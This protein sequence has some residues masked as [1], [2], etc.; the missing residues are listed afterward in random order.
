MSTESAV[1]GTGSTNTT[2]GTVAQA[3]TTF[4]ADLLLLDPKNAEVIVVPKE[5]AKAFV[6]EANQ[7]AALCNTLA[8]SRE[9]VLE[10]EEKLAQANAQ[11]FPSLGEIQPLQNKLKQ[12][13]TA[14]EA[15]YEAVKKELGDKGYLATS[16][17]GKE[18]LELVP[19][20]QRKSGGKPQ[21]WARTWTYVRPEKHRSHWRSVPL[22]KHDKGQMP[23][24]IRDGKIDHQEL[25]KQFGKL[26]PKLK[27]EWSFDPA[28]GFWFPELQAWAEQINKKS[29]GNNVSFDYGAQLFRYFAGFSAGYEW[30]PK[31]GKIAAKFNGKA[32][33]MLLSGKAKIEG[34][35]PA[36]DGWV[37]TLPGAN[38]QDVLIGAFRLFGEAKLEGGCGASASAELGIEVDYSEMRKKPVVKGGK[39]APPAAPPQTTA[40]LAAIGIEAGPGGDLFAG[41]KLSGELTG[42]LQYK[43]PEITNGKADEFGAIAQIGPKVEVQFG[44]GA[45][46]AFRVHY[47]KGRFRMRMK[48]GLC[49]G[50]GAKGEVG[51]EVDGRRIGKFIEWLFRAL[52]NADFHHLDIIT[53][54]GYLR[55]KQLQTML[56]NGVN[57]AYNDIELRWDTFM[58]RVDTEDQR[59][60]LMKRVLSNPPELRTCLPEAH[61]I[62]LYQLTRHNGLTKYWRWRD[63]TG[64]NFEF[65]AE[66]KKAVLQICKWAQCQRQF[67]S[68]VKHIGPNGEQGGFQGNLNG[69]KRFMELGMMDSD[70]DEQLDALYMRLPPEPPRGHPLHENDS[71]A[72]RTYARMGNSPQ[73]LALLRGRT[74]PL[75][76]FA[77]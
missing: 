28:A 64:L 25:K 50:P 48:A 73:Y 26:E 24:F 58:K 23:S 29:E 44:A 77:A 20:A 41:A 38:G 68:M 52:L 2:R 56:L 62:M 39:R 71:A 31:G 70:Y 36:K 67:K 40:K 54:E 59:I 18:L 30:N 57:D 32:E 4:D 42:A 43:S 11:M 19:L 45:A 5:H 63:N 21:P 76:S 74:T 53:E 72:F 51:L 55:A 22:S 46:A 34:Y 66:R 12:A 37:W 69:L 15:A 1:L 75:G 33:L 60:A 13:R 17:N 49:L 3:S 61:G 7:M 9:K 27:G 6:Q 47:D 10:L 14:Y 8:Q 35:L 16:G 65:M